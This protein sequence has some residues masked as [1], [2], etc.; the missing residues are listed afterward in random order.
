MTSGLHRLLI[1]GYW[2]AGDMQAWTFT[3]FLARELCTGEQERMSKRGRMGSGERHKY[4]TRFAA[5]VHC[6]DY[7]R[8]TVVA[9]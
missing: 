6:D 9:V 3:E 2:S 4:N 1:R 8:Y 7:Y 5:S